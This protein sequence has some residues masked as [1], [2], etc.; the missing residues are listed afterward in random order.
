MPTRRPRKRPRNRR[1]ELPKQRLPRARQR[2]PQLPSPDRRND[3]DR[4]RAPPLCLCC[5]PPLKGPG[6]N[7]HPTENVNVRK[8]IRC[9]RLPLTKF[10]CARE[11]GGDLSIRDHV[12]RFITKSYAWRRGS[13][14]SPG[15]RVRRL[16]VKW[17][18]QRRQ[19][20][21]GC[22]AAIASTRPWVRVRGDE[23]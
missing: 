4:S 8:V 17:V 21:T 2:S 11:L 9:L 6:N 1:L 5:C 23:L 3:L 22:V 12:E 13:A 20:A 18:L 19:R 15:R 10:T 14:C 7:N 16:R